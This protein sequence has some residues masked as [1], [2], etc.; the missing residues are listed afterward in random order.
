[1]AHRPSSSMGYAT[2]IRMNWRRCWLQSRLQ[3]LPSDT[4][5]GLKPS[6]LW[7]FSR[8]ECLRRTWF[9]HNAC[10]P[11]FEHHNASFWGRDIS[12]LYADIEALG[13]VVT[14]NFSNRDTIIQPHMEIVDGTF[15]YL[16]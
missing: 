1:M 13:R 11:V 16:L 7:L 3:C 9:V 4:P 15:L 12:S 8:L 10:L 14:K 5:H 2:M 6:S